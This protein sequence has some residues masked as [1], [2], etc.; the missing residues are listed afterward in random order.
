MRSPILTISSLSNAACNA[1]H[2][3]GD[4]EA[5]SRSENIYYFGPRSDPAYTIGQFGPAPVIL[6]VQVHLNPCRQIRIGERLNMAHV[7]CSL[8]SLPIIFEK[9][10]RTGTSA[11]FWFKYC[12]ASKLQQVMEFLQERKKKMR[13]LKSQPAV[14]TA[15]FNINQSCGLL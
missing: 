11:I 5:F 13:L 15:V 12:C 10:L 1:V 4:L 6:L 8:E 14:G 3:A 2:P 7:R 9:S